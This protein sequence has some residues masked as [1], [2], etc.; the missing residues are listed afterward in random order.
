MTPESKADLDAWVA[1][2]N[3]ELMHISNTGEDVGWDDK[4]G[5]LPQNI[6]LWT[7]LKAERPL[8]QRY[9]LS[10]PMYD[11]FSQSFDREKARLFEQH[12]QNPG[13]IAKPKSVWWDL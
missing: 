12:K 3:Q 8:D 10:N 1:D 5:R 11:Q 13:K 4:L 2:R 6:S 9:N 7:G